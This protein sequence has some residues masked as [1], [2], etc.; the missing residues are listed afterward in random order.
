MQQ[1]LRAGPSG[2]VAFLFSDIEGSTARWSMYP[3]AMPVCLHRHDELLHASI[4]ANGGSVF[5][6]V[7]DEFCAAFASAESAAQAA[8]DA[9][10]ALAQEDWSAIGGLRVRMAVHCGPVTERGGD[11][12]GSTV[13]R[14]ARLLSA[15]HGGQIIVSAA[16]ARMLPDRDAAVALRDL[17]RHRLKDFPELESI[18]Q[19]VAPALPEIFPPLRTVAERPSNLPQHLA[20]LLGRENEVAHVVDRLRAH[21]LVSITGAGGVGK[22]SIAVQIGADLLEQFEDGVWLAELAPVDA[23]AVAPTIAGVFGITG[24][25]GGSTIDAVAAHLKNKQLLLIVDNCEHVTEAAAAAINTILRSCAGVRILATSREP[26][27]LGGEAVYKLPVLAV[28]PEE[29]VL[30]ED[31]AA[32]GACRLFAERARAHVPAFEITDEN[33]RTVARICRR[34]DGIALAIELAA[35]RLRVLSLDQLDTRLA[36]R[37][38]LLTGG[39]RQALPH[40]QTLR[41]LIDW[42]Y[43]LLTGNERMLL[44]RSALFPGGWSIGGAVEV[45]ADE[46][47]EEWDLLDHLTSLVDKSLVIVDACEPEPRYRMLESTREYA[48]E[49]LEESGERDAIARRHAEYFFGLANRADEA[50]QQVPAK[51]WIAPLA[52][53]LDNVR[54]A[55]SWC[56]TQQNDTLLGIRIFNALEAFWWD[57]QPVEGR[58]WIDELHSY[59]EANAASPEYARYALAASGI[60]LSLAQEKKAVACARAALEAYRHLGAER[61]AAAAQRCLGSALIRMQKPDEGEA[62]IA[63][64]LEIFRRNGDRRLTALALRSIAAA[65]LLRGEMEKAGEIYREALALSQALQDERGVQIIAGNL[66]EIEA[67]AG[68][69]GKAI[70]H[71]REALE[72]ARARRDW[73]MACTLLINVTAYLLACERM[74]E[75]RSTAREALSIACEIQSEMHLAVAIQ[76]LGAIA[77]HCGDP[78]RAA[79]LIGFTDAAYQRLENAREPTEAQEYERTMALLGE[80]LSAGEVLSNVSAGALLTNEGAVS[81]ALLT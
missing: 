65:P 48:I 55:L 70:E 8:I 79:R 16:A 18:Y 78:A 3:E 75:A 57:A 51:E 40:H 42:S 35:P 60:A 67:L 17:G 23:D 63:S 62:A 47:L 29:A 37:F 11:Y 20:P 21:R 28:P 26:L 41:A 44:R 52:R 34:L 10:R 1:M 36:E 12:F 4:A 58:R 45:C 72:I 54:A 27:A 77:A 14:V 13:N 2:D 7:G 50:W 19:L 32:F 24:A 6:T 76:H 53:E 15:G 30:A 39:N 25:G 33:A 59:A 49:R 9:Q 80:R 5:K 43:G 31:V 71:G 38:R 81:E 74:G 46:T 22:T 64:A 68:S 56:V 66:A 73:V 61:G 69:Y